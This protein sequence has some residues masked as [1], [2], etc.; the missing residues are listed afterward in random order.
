MKH[1]LRRRWGSRG[2]ITVFVT[3]IL[4]PAIAIAGLLVDGSRVQLAKAQAAAAGDL[5]LNAALANYDAVL[6]DVYG[7][8]AVSQAADD[9]G[10]ALT[11]N[12]YAY[13][14]ST[15]TK[16]GL[17]SVELSL[18]LEE[19]LNGGEEDVATSMLR[20]EVL[21]EEFQA[22]GVA[23]SQLAQPK[24]L[25]HQ[26]VEFEKYRAPA[27]AI[28]ALI[29]Q[30]TGIKKQME[31]MQAE[32]EVVQKQVEVNE[33]VED[34]NDAAKKV[35]LELGT[36]GTD[37]TGGNWGGYMKQLNDG[38][39]S[40]VFTTEAGRS[41][42]SAAYQRAFEAAVAVFNTGDTAGPPV[43]S[44][45]TSSLFVG[46]PNGTYNGVTRPPTPWV[47]CSVQT[48]CTDADAL[49]AHMMSYQRDAQTA[50]RS[51]GASCVKAYR[52][53]I[54]ELYHF[55]RVVAEDEDGITQGEVDDAWASRNGWALRP[56]Y[57]SALAAWD[58]LNTYA[59]DL[60]IEA[61]AQ[62]NADLEMLRHLID[63]LGRGYNKLGD[64]LREVGEVE[65]ANAEYEAAYQDP[66]NANRLQC[67]SEYEDDHDLVA[68]AFSRAN[69]EA[70]R[71]KVAEVKTRLDTIRQGIEGDSATGVAP[72]SL[73][74]EPLKDLTSFDDFK[75][76]MNSAGYQI[77]QFWRQDGNPPAFFTLF[78]SCQ[79]A[80]S[81]DSFQLDHPERS[82]HA[83]F[84]EE[85]R[86]RFENGDDGDGAEDDL[87][88]EVEDGEDKANNHIGF[89]AA[90]SSPDPETSISGAYPDLPSANAGSAGTDPPQ[91]LEADGHRGFGDVA[92]NLM[93]GLGSMIVELAEGLRDDI[94]TVHYVSTNFSWATQAKEIEKSGAASS[95][96]SD[97]SL[98]LRNPGYTQTGFE[99][100][101]A[102]NA[103]YGSEI[104]YIISGRDTPKANVDVNVAKI[105]LIRFAINAIHAISDRGYDRNPLGI[106]AFALPAA[107]AISAA[108]WGVVPVKLIEVVLDLVWAAAE[109]VSD[110]IRLAA[111][112]G[113]GLLKKKSS[114]TNAF[115][116][117]KVYPSLSTLEAAIGDIDED[118]GATTDCDDGNITQGEDGNVAGEE[119]NSIRG[120]AAEA[121]LA[122]PYS[123][124]L[125][126]FLMIGL[127]G[128]GEAVLKRIADVI[129]INVIYNAGESGSGFAT[130]NER[131]Y[132]HAR[133]AGFRMREAYTWVQLDAVVRVQPLFIGGAPYD[134]TVDLTFAE[135]GR[136]TDYGP[137]QFKFK[138][139][140][141]VGY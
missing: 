94:Y 83:V 51:S 77:S 76:A 109:S 108:T 55:D 112:E 119:G 18:G 48:G 32:N 97:P 42:M 95:P 121:V 2:S 128:E 33:A 21:K 102:N 87:D 46:G 86:S 44:S 64:L 63:R 116:G 17:D 132:K 9:P 99:I 4:A 84:Y 71:T 47:G 58:S 27:E 12:L 15:L 49:H 68:D 24:I 72:A 56:I 93:E 1:L 22:L 35:W 118:E 81:D 65:T 28:V 39:Q 134:R 13:F 37:R 41:Y 135:G 91:D 85:L 45:N 69:I 59:N 16:T 106:R 141:A 120:Q 34:A 129:Q 105:F 117:W 74:G 52:E 110:M 75:A 125:Q 137:G 138:Y 70:L 113:V 23:G 139:S 3:M 31:G 26:I 107:T 53:L 136:P 43:L 140:G 88:D 14:H 40:P 7:L 100:K 90:P 126:V 36:W 20:M 122:F 25:Q 62:V 61:N 123:R 10:Q 66:D 38:R 114:D 101:A 67:S 73:A 79:A 131:S 96:E 30:F 5:A 50:C 124:Y 54:S 103:F 11:D 98:R 92:G 89:P 80:S 8:F 78:H 6:Q 104:E 82:P 127:A 29:N 57:N 19:M 111:G 115:D 60:F 130:L 133:G